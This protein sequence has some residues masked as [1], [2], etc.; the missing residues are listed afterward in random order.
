MSGRIASLAGN[1]PAA[2]LAYG[3]D[4]TAAT[5]VDQ[6]N[7]LPVGKGHQLVADCLIS[8]G[9]SLSAAV[10]LGTARLVGI[11]TPA[12]FEPTALTFQSSYDGATWNN[13]YDGTGTEKSITVA[14]S[15]RVILSP[16]DFYGI[17]Y[18]KVRGGRPGRQQQSAPIA[19]S[20]WWRKPDVRAVRPGGPVHGTS[21]SSPRRHPRPRTHH[22]R[23]FLWRHGNERRRHSDRRHQRRRLA[24]AD[25]G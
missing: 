21:V 13:V 4:G 7:P 24:D 9:Q 2:G 23:R 12:A 17:R 8:N 16:A 22:R 10:D 6:S 19:P 20:S 5:F 1:V 14:A 3:G 11:A 18:I 15:R 25:G